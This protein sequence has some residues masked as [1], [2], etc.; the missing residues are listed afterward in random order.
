MTPSEQER[1]ARERIKSWSWTPVP[2][3]RLDAFRL[4]VRRAVLAEAV[5]K[6]EGLRHGYEGQSTHSEYPMGYENAQEDVVTALRGL[7][8][9]GE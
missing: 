7:S 5:A 1:E 8:P 4:A 6:V 9:E 3:E 2:D